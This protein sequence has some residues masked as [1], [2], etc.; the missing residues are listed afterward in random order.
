[1]AL[2]VSW[3][4]SV[5]VG[6]GREGAEGFL[7]GLLEEGGAPPPR[8]SLPGAQDRS[9]DSRTG[10]VVFANSDLLSWVPRTTHSPGESGGGYK[11]LPRRA[12]MALW[13]RPRANP[14]QRPLLLLFSHSVVSCSL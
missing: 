1:M 3:G 5:A 12:A 8:W 2:G 13:Y 11:P 4:G 6:G 14:N 10:R 7:P 9:G